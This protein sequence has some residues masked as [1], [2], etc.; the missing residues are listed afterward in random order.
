MYRPNL[1]AVD[2]HTDGQVLRVI[3]GGVPALKGSTIA[4][5]KADF[6]ANYDEIRRMTCLEPRGYT[7]MFAAFLMPS[8]NPEADFGVLFFDGCEFL[9]MCG[10]GTIAACTVIVDSSMVRVTE[11]YTTVVLETMAGIVRAKVK[12][13]NGKAKSVTLKNVPAFLYKENV[14]VDVPSIGTIH[15]D[16]AYGGSFFAIVP[17]EEAGVDITPGN[18]RYS[19][20]P[21]GMDILRAVNE[22]IKVQHPILPTNTISIVE[23]SGPARSKGADRQN[24]IIYGMNQAGR[25]PCGTGTSAKM[26]ALHAKGELALNTQFVHE[27]VVG[28]FFYGQLLEETKVGDYPA[29]I[30]EITGSAYI[31]GYNHFVVD[32]DDP[33]KYGIEF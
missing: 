1:F 10:D 11:P 15:C 12:V 9:D 20:I 17:C 19:V 5:K 8:C 16:I 6:V 29:V 14:A 28:T 33:V 27:S 2:A 31:T 26:A 22:Q 7:D 24:V 30:P 4:E 25:S 3:T 21:K 23:F 32:E 18:L 13:E